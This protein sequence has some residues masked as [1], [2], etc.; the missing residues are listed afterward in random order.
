MNN[1]FGKSNLNN[2]ICYPCIYNLEIQSTVCRH[3]PAGF[4]DGSGCGGSRIHLQSEG[5]KENCNCLICNTDD[6]F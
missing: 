5:E 4:H 1:T 2:G 6:L 3:S